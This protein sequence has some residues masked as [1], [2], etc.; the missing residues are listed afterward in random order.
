MT[1]ATQLPVEGRDKDVGLFRLSNGVT[2]FKQVHQEEP[3]YDVYEVDVTQSKTTTRKGKNGDSLGKEELDRA[4]RILEKSAQ[5][6][7]K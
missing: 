3:I 6:G 1:V 2:S 5:E 7:L 4:L